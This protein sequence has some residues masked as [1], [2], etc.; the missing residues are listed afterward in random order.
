MDLVWI[1]YNNQSQWNEATI[2][3]IQ[4]ST[5]NQIQWWKSI[6]WI[7]YKSHTMI[8]YKSHTMIKGNG[9]DLLWNKDNDQSQLNKSNVNHI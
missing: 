5:I 6:K 1:K 3:H 8:Y 4:W 9:I 7:Y 2:N